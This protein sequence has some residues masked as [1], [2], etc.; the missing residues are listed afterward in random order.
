MKNY[1]VKEGQNPIDIALEQYGVA[2]MLFQLIDDNP[3]IAEQNFYLISGQVLRIDETKIVNKQVVEY[4]NREGHTVNTGME[5]I[6]FAEFS[7][8]FGFDFDI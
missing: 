5:E 4:Y 1:T 2:E 6:P 8:D 3:E 7:D